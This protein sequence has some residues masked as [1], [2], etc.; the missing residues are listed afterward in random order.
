MIH[1]IELDPPFDVVFPEF[2]EPGN[3]PD[4]DESS[5]VLKCLDFMR[6]FGIKPASLL[7]K[8]TLD[9]VAL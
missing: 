5:K 6:G 7:N 3:I 9:Q 1:R 4:W 2:W 8:I